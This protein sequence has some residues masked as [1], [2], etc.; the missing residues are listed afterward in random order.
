MMLVGGKGKCNGT[1]FQGTEMYKLHI[2]WG[3][4]F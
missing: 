1:N 4:G 3:I 2:T